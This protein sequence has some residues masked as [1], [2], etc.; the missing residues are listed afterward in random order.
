MLDAA[1]AATLVDATTDAAADNEIDSALKQLPSI[2]GTSNALQGDE[3]EL[4]KFL[5]IESQPQTN[6]IVFID[7]SLIHISE[8][9][10]PY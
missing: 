6:E 9:T 4:T 10:R 2:E 7:L 1:A 8:P 3:S 5:E